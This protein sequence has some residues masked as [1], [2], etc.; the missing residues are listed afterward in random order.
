MVFHDV[1][2]TAWEAFSPICY[3]RLIFMIRFYS[4]LIGF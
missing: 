3:P 1:H 4:L 2:G